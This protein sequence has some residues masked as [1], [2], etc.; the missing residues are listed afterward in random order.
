[1]DIRTQSIG[2]GLTWLAHAINVGGRN[3]GAVFGAAF[4]FIVAMY[5]AAL[6]GMLPLLLTVDREALPETGALLF[7]MLPM[8]LLVLC[9]VPV[10][11]GGLMHVV[12]EADASRPVRARD[13][14][15]PWREGKVG[16]LALLGLVQVVFALFA[17]LMLRWL[18]GPNYWHDYMAALRSAI[19]GTF[20]V[21]PGPEH[22]GLLLLAQLLFNYFSYSIMLFSIPLVMFSGVPLKDA[23]R[24]SLRSAI[25]NAGPCLLTGVLF[26]A[27]SIAAA[28]L[29]L[30]L[31]GVAGVLGALIH[32]I[33]AGMLELVLMLAFSVA[34]LAVVASVTHA[35]WRDI[36]WADA[37][38][39]AEFAA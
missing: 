18:E 28:A 29:M 33:V 13:I 3:P 25:R 8:A 24:L 30:V 35:A 38:S 5:L 23:V 2:R 32:P 31:V 12:R 26:I 14:F 21:M 1:M 15:A 6:L 7:R 36:F 9:L 17:V 11:F 39:V 34:L 22:P 20:R 19:G 37:G 10:L 27:G 4:L 16:K